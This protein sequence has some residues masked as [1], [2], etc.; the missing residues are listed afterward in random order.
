MI[1]QD[2]LFVVISSILSVGNFARRQKEKRKRKHRARKN[3]VELSVC[4]RH[5]WLRVNEDH[6]A[7][8]GTR[9][10]PEVLIRIRGTG[11]A[12]RRL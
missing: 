5:V 11:D 4:P 2:N 12:C 3:R 6:T 9:T 8:T 10:A 1:K 7:L